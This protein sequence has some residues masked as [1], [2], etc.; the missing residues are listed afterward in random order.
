MSIQKRILEIKTEYPNIKRSLLIEK[1]KAP[2]TLSRG[3]FFLEYIT[4]CLPL[5]K[6]SNFSVER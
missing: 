2:T 4:Y 5:S 3:S 1:L 6:I